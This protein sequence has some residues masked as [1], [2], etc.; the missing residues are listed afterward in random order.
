VQK[1]IWVRFSIWLQSVVLALSCFVYFTT[2]KKA[3]LSVF[4]V[5]IGIFPTKVFTVHT[6]YVMV[7]LVLLILLVNYNLYAQN[8]LNKIL[9]WFQN[10]VFA[11]LSF[12]FLDL[13]RVDRT[14]IRNFNSNSLSILGNLNPNIWLIA[15]LLLIA[16]IS[17]LRLKLVGILKNIGFIALLFGLLFQFVVFLSPTKEL[18]VV[19]FVEF[20]YWH[21]ALFLLIFWSFVYYPMSILS[22]DSAEENI[23]GKFILSGLYHF[24]IFGLAFVLIH[25]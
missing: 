4:E 25:I 9:L 24:F 6:G 1:N 10:L 20:T 21:K 17:I 22:S 13:L 3:I 14:S 12:S 23:R 2:V 5:N 11:V 7:P 8:N 15:C 18:S 16:I 19:S